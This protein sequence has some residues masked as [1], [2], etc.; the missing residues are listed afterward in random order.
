MVKVESNNWQKLRK[1]VTL[2]EAE[3]AVIVFFLTFDHSGSSLFQLCSSIK[4]L[5]FIEHALIW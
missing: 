5:V 4:A 3:E 2:I 1:N